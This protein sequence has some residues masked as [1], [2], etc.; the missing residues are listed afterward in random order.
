MAIYDQYIPGNILSVANI[1]LKQK[2]FRAFY[3]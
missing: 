2:Q 1:S 3:E